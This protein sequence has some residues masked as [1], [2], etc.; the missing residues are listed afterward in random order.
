MRGLWL[1]GFG[2]AANYTCVDACANRA[3]YGQ[4][5]ASICYN[6]TPTVAIY[7]DAINL[8]NSKTHE[9]A[10]NEGHFLTLEDVGR[11]VNVGLRMS[12]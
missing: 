2:V 7:A 4:T 8:A 3:A 11:R 6:L 5:D 9:Y 12:F 10:Q 1:R